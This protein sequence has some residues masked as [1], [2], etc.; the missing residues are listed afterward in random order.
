MKKISNPDRQNLILL[1]SSL[2]GS[3]IYISL[4]F[5]NNLWVDEAF[6][7]SL[8]RGDLS[9]VWTATVADTLPPFYN[10]FTKMITILLGYS[11]PSMKFSSVLAAVLVLFYGSFQIKRLYSFRDALIFTVF[12]LSMPYYFYYAVEIRPYSWGLFFS[13]AAALAFREIILENTLKGYVKFALFTALSGYAH[14]FAL[15]ASAVLWFFLLI[16]LIASGKKES[17]KKFFTAFFIFTAVYLPCLILAVYQIKNASSYFSMSPLTFSSFLSD[18]RFPFVTH[19]TPLSLLLMLLFILALSSALLNIFQRD[20]SLY[21]PTVYAA[22]PY[23]VLLFGYA[24]SFAAGSS[25]FT[26]RYLVPS[27][28]I[29][30]LGTSILLSAALSKFPDKFRRAASV[31]I[32]VI[33]AASAIVN[34][35]VQFK[36]EYDSSVNE[37]T[38]WFDKNLTPDDGYIIY[39]SAYQIEICM[40]YYYP[41]L[42]KYDRDTVDEIKGNIWYFEVEGYENELEKFK[43]MGYNIVYIKQM[44]F[45]RY[46]FNLYRLE[47]PMHTDVPGN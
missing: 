46:S 14:H 26:S 30:W 22:V 27:L 8:V 37:M 38:E 3:I 16:Y 34:Y 40:R 35:T 39:E 44:S 45:D 7:A 1:I 43:S 4:I 23:C 20:F 6:T 21:C 13:F 29:F 28:G 42:K 11:A 12:F 25:Y 10:L 19:Y 18:L 32:A 24:A 31:T 17:V 47:K 2:I 9:E 15:V 41:G 36:S 5:N 33:I